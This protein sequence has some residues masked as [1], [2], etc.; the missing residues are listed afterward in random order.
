MHI[1]ASFPR[2]IVGKE[3]AYGYFMDKRAK[4]YWS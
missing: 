1:I 3:K 4:G 2:G